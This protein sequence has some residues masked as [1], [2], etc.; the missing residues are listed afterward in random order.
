ML[1]CVYKAA[2]GE[3]PPLPAFIE[4][5][6]QD[7]L[8]HIALCAD[9]AC[10]A[11]AHQFPRFLPASMEA[12][13]QPCVNPAALAAAPKLL[14]RSAPAVEPTVQLLSGFA[15]SA[16]ALAITEQLH[17]SPEAATEAALQLGAKS[18]AA[19]QPGTAA[20]PVAAQ[21]AARQ[22]GGSSVAVTEVAMDLR[23]QP[24]TEAE[25]GASGQEMPSGAV[26]CRCES[27]M[28]IEA[29]TADENPQHTRKIF[30]PP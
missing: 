10:I 21:I 15:A 26:P 4:H 29:A 6:Q 19:A 18:K 9:P 5:R 8:R 3:T 16:S 20:D 1:G 11:A 2:Y 13:L 24:T 17:S 30:T 7:H 25:T 28:E 22:P 23:M 12:A 14:G 27:A